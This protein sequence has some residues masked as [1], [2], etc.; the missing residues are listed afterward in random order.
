MAPS[1]PV[2]F[3]RRLANDQT[4]LVGNSVLDG[5]P[6][7]VTR[8]KTTISADMTGGADLTAAPAAGEKIVVDDVI[9]SAA[10]EM[11][12]SFLEETSG[13][14]IF[15]LYLPANGLAQVTPRGKLKLDTAN[16]KLRGDAS[17]AGG[18]AVMVLY[19]SEE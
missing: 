2:E 7:W 11:Y 17:A 6:D 18:V 5:G 9:V 19:H 8:R 15:R 4:L 13:T 16:K 14:E 3:V 10:A 12:L 1:N